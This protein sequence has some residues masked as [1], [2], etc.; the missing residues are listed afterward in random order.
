[1]NHGKSAYEIDVL[2]VALKPPQHKANVEGENL[3]R[4]IR[5][6]VQ[7]VAPK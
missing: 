2:D 4:S 5:Q 7:F 3:V 6:P 1:M